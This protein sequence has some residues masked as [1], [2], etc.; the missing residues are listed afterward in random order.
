[1]RTLIVRGRSVPGEPETT[2]LVRQKRAAISSRGGSAG[3]SEAAPTGRPCPGMLDSVS[4]TGITDSGYGQSLSIFALPRF[5]S[6]PSPTSPGERVGEG[7]RFRPL[8]PPGFRYA[9]PG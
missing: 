1:M 9:I 8:R 4:S 7:R 2:S 6:P 3:S 5:S